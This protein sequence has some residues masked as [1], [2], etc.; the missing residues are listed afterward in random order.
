MVIRKVFI[1]NNEEQ[2]MPKEQ[3]MSKE[4]DLLPCPFCGYKQPILYAIDTCNDSA[5]E[6]NCG[7]C[8]GYVWGE[9]EEAAKEAWNKRV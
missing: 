6:V 3:D 9:T 8:Q 4:Q 1:M 7:Q 2:D 5:W